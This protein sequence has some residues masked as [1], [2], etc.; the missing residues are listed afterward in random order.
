MLTSFDGVVEIARCRL[1]IL[2]T[3]TSLIGFFFVS[4][5]FFKI[6][7]AFSRSFY[8]LSKSI[9]LF[10]NKSFIYS[11]IYI[12]HYRQYYLL[13]L[14]II[15]VIIFCWLSKQVVVKQNNFF[16]F[17]INRDLNNKFCVSKNYYFFILIIIF[18]WD[19]SFFYKFI[20]DN[21]C[22]I[23]KYI[24]TINFRFLIIFKKL[25]TRNERS[26]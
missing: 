4:N 6:S 1:I 10:K 8:Y 26:R 14:Q 11:F 21:F 16:I 22:R 19:W 13:L 25:S 3:F 17:F 20:N 5:F 18:F 15:I 12:F 7:T 24:V 9:S 23:F 2:S